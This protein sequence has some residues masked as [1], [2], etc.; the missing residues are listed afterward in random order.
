M[1]TELKKESDQLQQSLGKFSQ[2]MQRAD[3]YVQTQSNM[4]SLMGDLTDYFVRSIQGSVDHRLALKLGA[5]YHAVGDDVRAD[6]WRMIA[7]ADGDQAAK[8]LDDAHPK[9]N[10]VITKIIDDLGNDS[11]IKYF[12]D[13]SFEKTKDR[14]LYDVLRP[15]LVNSTLLPYEVKRMWDDIKKFLD[16]FRAT[17]GE[18]GWGKVQMPNLALAAKDLEK[19]DSYY[20]DAT[21]TYCDRPNEGQEAMPNWKK[22]IVTTGRWVSVVTCVIIGILTCNWAISMQI[23]RTWVEVEVSVRKFCG[24]ICQ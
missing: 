7:K 14:M 2:A 6:A 19:D 5:R 8:V 3:A 20:K 4:N 10:E 24:W 13:P 1:N 23:V 9:P 22:E 16:E 21:W 17:G 15:A 11:L 18:S 12:N